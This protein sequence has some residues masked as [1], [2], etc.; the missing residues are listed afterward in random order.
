MTISGTCVHGIHRCV[1]LR[2]IAIRLDSMGFVSVLR[3]WGV[4]GGSV[5][6]LIIDNCFA[7]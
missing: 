4:W 3:N 5:I 7:I 2:N 1:W 6:K